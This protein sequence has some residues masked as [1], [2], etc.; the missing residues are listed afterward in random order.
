VRCDTRLQTTRTAPRPRFLPF[1]R[2][3]ER[4]SVKERTA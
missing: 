2:R 4:T 1:D 3:I